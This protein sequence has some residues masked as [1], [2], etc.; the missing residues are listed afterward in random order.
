MVSPRGDPPQTPKTPHGDKPSAAGIEP[1]AV[2]HL[3]QAHAASTPVVTPFGP[4]VP[5]ADVEPPAGERTPSGPDSKTADDAAIRVSIFYPMG[6]EAAR[7]RFTNTMME[8]TQKKSK[9]P[10]AFQVI[11]AV[12]TTVA[13]ENSTDWIWTAK[14]NGANCFFVILPPDVMIDFMEPLLAEAREAGLRCFLVPQAEVGSKLL[15][16]DL[17]VELMMIKRKGK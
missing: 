2:A 14:A 10:L 7:D 11:N 1:M 6:G 5:A 8:M 9:K 3:P 12:P 4:A 15:Y 16:M 13:L 17:M